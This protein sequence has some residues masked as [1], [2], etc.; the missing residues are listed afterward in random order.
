MKLCLEFGKLSPVWSPRKKKDFVRSFS[1]ITNIY[2]YFNKYKKSQAS[3]S[4][5]YFRRQMKTCFSPSDPRF[6]ARFPFPLAL[7][8]NSTFRYS[9]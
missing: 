5:H 9:Q 4:V 7:A 2:Y 8:L 6:K 1:L 3:F